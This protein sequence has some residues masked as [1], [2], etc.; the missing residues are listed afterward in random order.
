MPR[1]DPGDDGDTTTDSTT[2]STDGTSGAATTALEGLG[3]GWIATYDD[4]LKGFGKRPIQ[5]IGG[6][7]LTLLLNGFEQLTVSLLDAV[8]AVGDS[9]ASVPTLTASVL[10]D[11]GSS[12]GLLIIDLIRAVNEPLLTAA[13]AAGPLAPVVGTAIVA[14]ELVV[15]VWVGQLLVSVLLD[16]IPGLGG[17]Q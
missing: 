7:M 9:V 4:V 12:T 17:L 11:A 5:F 15:V 13:Q 6:A 1:L 8:L 3:I 16:I 2:D 14:G 10:T